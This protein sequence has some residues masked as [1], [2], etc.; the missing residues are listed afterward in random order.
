MLIPHP[1]HTRADLLAWDEY[2]A[3]DLIHGRRAALAAKTRTA[4][5]AVESFVRDRGSAYVSVSWG[6]DSTVLAALCAGLDLPHV[7]VREVPTANPECELVRDAF[8]RL[9]PETRY[10]EIEVHCRRGQYTWHATGSLESGFATAVERH[11]RHYITGVRRDESG[12]RAL[13]FFVHGLASR[14]T[15]APITLWTVADVFGYLAVHDLPI[16]PVYAMLGGGRWQRSQ[17]RVC[18]LGGQRGA[19]F[20]RA[21]WEDEY[22]GD[23]IAELRHQR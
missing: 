22:Y 23:R 13:R 4:R 7:W 6:K 18:S 5:E 15:L 12:S 17:L 2:A 21:E 19:S 10:D 8:L 1:K 9:Y 3:A 14:Y 20:G 16:H 11:G